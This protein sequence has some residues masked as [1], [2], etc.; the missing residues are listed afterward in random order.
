M[1][2]GHVPAAVAQAPVAVQ[3]VERVACEVRPLPLAKFFVLTQGPMMQ[4]QVHLTLL[5]RLSSQSTKSCTSFT[6][7]PALCL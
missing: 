6:Q 3:S 1:Q 2:D 7:Q 5:M 4:A